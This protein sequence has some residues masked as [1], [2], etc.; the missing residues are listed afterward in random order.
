M[1]LAAY[2][3]SNDRQ[4]IFNQTDWTYKLITG[5]V[6]HTLVFGTEFGNQKS[7]NA[8][9]SGIFGN[10]SVNSAAISA[11]NPVS[12]MPVSFTGLGTDARN[13]NNLKL[14]AVYG[15][16]QI[17]LTKWLQ[18]IGGVR[19]DRFDLGYVNLNAQSG[20]WARPLAGSTT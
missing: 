10:G 13:Q 12:Y 19:F 8:R 5:P 6:K 3:N 20:T 18:I 9:F 15:Q 16:D 7:A 2:N 4:N 11:S 14:A 1:T 17:E